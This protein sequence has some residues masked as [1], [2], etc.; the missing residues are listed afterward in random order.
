MAEPPM[1]RILRIQ[2]DHLETHSPSPVDDGV[3]MLFSGNCDK[4][5]LL[6]TAGDREAQRHRAN[7]LRSILRR[8]KVDAQQRDDALIMLGHANYENDIA[9]SMKTLSEYID[10][11]LEATEDG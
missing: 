2:Y 1:D 9:V 5:F 6:H 7:Y 10:E 8:I 4:C 3:P 11:K